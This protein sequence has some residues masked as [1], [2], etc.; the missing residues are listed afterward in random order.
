MTAERTRTANRVRRIAW[1]RNYAFRIAVSDIFVVAASVGVTQLIW[2]GFESRQLAW[3][4]SLT[5]GYTAVSLI[6]AATWLF[7]LA[8]YSTRNRKIIGSGTLEYKR[9][10]DATLRM[11]G[12]LAVVAYLGEIE[13]ARGYFL[14]ALPFGLGLLLLSRWSWRQWLRKQQEEG[15]FLSRAILVGERLKSVHVAH[16]IRRAPGTGM[17]I[18]GAFTRSGT[19][20]LNLYDDIPVLGDFNDL[21]QGI[22]DYQI[23]SVILTGADDIGPIDMRKLGWD[24]GEREVELI[25]AP[26][27]TDVAGPRIHSRPVAGLPLIH[28]EYPTL[29]GPKR[30]AKRASDIAGSALLIVLL[31]IPLLVVAI[32]IKATSPGNLIYRQE[33]IGRGGRP[34]GMLK[35]RS[36]VKDADDQLESLLDAQGTSDTPL[37]KVINDPRITP[38][39]KFIRKYSIDEFPQLFNVLFGQ[40][41]LVGPRPQ[42]AAEVALYDDI[43]HRRLIMK[44]GMS[45]LWQVSGRSDLSWEDAI[46]LDLY[47]VENWSMTADLLILFRTVR[48]VVAPTGAH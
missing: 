32:I 48:A 30:F 15:A 21:L 10:A 27:L 47:Y 19:T 12:V 35:F 28:V 17:E 11:F 31:S 26:A 44:P 16:T 20:S 3:N 25:V 29:E 13:L 18:V 1:Q 5:L 34:F 42:R 38:I 8:A 39:G 23:D 43:A 24:L 33:R 6:V 36:M 37:F 40:M 45:G 14:T 4:I 9:V 41:S 2:F 22:D 7:V 46:R